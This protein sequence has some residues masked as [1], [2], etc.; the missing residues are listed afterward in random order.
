MM[1]RSSRMLP[2]HAYDRSSF[3]AAGD[4]VGAGRSCSLAAL[5]RNERASGSIS[6]AR[7]RSGGITSEMP[8]SR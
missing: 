8:F 1:L 5:S 3:S 7:A 2:G 4:S 6:S